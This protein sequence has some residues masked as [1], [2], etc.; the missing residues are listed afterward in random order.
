MGIGYSGAR[1]MVTDA[2]NTI[3]P[4]VF[5]GKGFGDLPDSFSWLRPFAM[6]GAIIEA[7]FVK[8]DGPLYPMTARPIRVGGGRLSEPDV[9]GC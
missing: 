6:T 7:G 3:Q 4:A 1:G 8:Q 9:G 2:P 5:F